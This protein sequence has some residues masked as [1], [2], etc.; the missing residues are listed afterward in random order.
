M[1]YEIDLNISKAYISK[2]T[3]NN[4]IPYIYN[5]LILKN[6]KQIAYELSKAISEESFKA[7]ASIY[8]NNNFLINR[9]KE[10]L[11]TSLLKENILL[12]SKNYLDNYISN[13]EI[14]NNINWEEN[15]NILQK[16]SQLIEKIEKLNQLKE[17]NK[18]LKG[19]KHGI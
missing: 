16:N 3:F 15:F 13:I 2:G 12:S 1:K 6:D 11:P 17:F 4:F 18:Q 14:K 7:D 9:I 19:K 10:T 8:L 5:K